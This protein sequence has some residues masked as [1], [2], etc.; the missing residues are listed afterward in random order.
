MLID[1]KGDNPLPGWHRTRGLAEFKRDFPGRFV[2]VVA[3]RAPFEDELAWFDGVCRHAFWTGHVAVGLDDLPPVLTVN[4]A[5]SPGL[6][7]LYKLGRSRKVMPIGCLQRARSVPLVM[8]SEA[9]QL[10]VFSLLLDEDRERVRQVIGD[11]PAP[12]DE[13]SFV[14]ARSGGLTPAVLCRP[15]RL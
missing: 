10:F 14:W 7:E 15:L 1:Y 6:E 13:H 4:G 12:A 11:F 5:R 8:F 3:Q 2:R 9:S